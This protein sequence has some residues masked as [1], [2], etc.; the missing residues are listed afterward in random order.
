M[1]ELTLL[2]VTHSGEQEARKLIPYIQDCDVFGIEG[3]ICTEREA[4]ENERVW[5]RLL[6]TDISRSR[7][8]EMPYVSI[9]DEKRRVYT[10]KVIDYLFRN[11]RLLWSTERFTEEEAQMVK[12]ICKKSDLLA[13]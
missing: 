3:A 11:K 1:I 8:Q 10:A 13:R 9:L 7:L 2:K 6:G 5:Q 4:S 12:N